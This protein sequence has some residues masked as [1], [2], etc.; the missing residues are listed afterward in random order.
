MND[1]WNKRHGPDSNSVLLIA[2]TP[3]TKENYLSATT[4]LFY[5][6]ESIL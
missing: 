3:R 5:I 4:F 1:L 6:P 2:M